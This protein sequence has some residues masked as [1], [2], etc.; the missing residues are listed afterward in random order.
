VAEFT[1]I[2]SLFNPNEA[3]FRETGNRAGLST[4]RQAT[5]TRETKKAREAN[6]EPFYV[7]SQV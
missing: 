7:Q 5:G 4:G 2:D 3:G 6:P 1:T